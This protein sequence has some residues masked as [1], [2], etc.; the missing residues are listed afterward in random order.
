MPAEFGGAEL[1]LFRRA[2]DGLDVALV[3]P[4][5]A[6]EKRLERTARELEQQRHLKW[7]FLDLLI[8]KLEGL[9]VAVEGRFDTHPL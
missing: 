5:P 3:P 4:G 8:E 9:R 7:C 6:E 1:E 2:L